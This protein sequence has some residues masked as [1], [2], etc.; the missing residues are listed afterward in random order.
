[1]ILKKG[2]SVHPQN[3][4]LVNN[5]KIQVL[6]QG[7]IYRYLETEESGGKQLQQRKKY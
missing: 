3:L 1:M 4:I 2:K 5:R 7:K 6:E